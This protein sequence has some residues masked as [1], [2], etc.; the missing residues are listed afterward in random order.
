MANR[1][2]QM[3]IQMQIWNCKPGNANPKVQTANSKMQIANWK[4]ENERPVG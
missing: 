2:L 1:K 3:Q 4:L